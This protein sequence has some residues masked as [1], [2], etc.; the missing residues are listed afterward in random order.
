MKKTVLILVSFFFLVSCE[1]VI[2]VDLPAHKPGIVVNCVMKEGKPVSASITRSVG[3]LDTLEIEIING[4][5]VKLYENGVFVGTL[6][7][8]S[9]EGV[10]SVPGEYRINHNAVAGAEYRLEVSAPA[11][12]PV[13][14]GA[15]IPQAVPIASHVFTENASVNQFGE[16]MS[17]LSVTIND[18]AGIDNYY[19]LTI[20]DTTETESGYYFSMESTDPSVVQT[21]TGSGILFSDELFDGKTYTLK[22]DIPG[23]S[24]GTPFSQ[25][26]KVVLQTIDRNDFL[27]Q[28]TFYLHIE[29]EENPFAEPVQVY[30]N[31]NGGLGIFGGYSVN[32]VPL[33]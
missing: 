3:I 5:D 31:I 14:A 18:P 2:D 21:Y 13:Q 19:F 15:T 30:T 8:N 20:I 33:Y 32:S 26:M 23:F 10:D 6:L 12:D 24:G 22:A 27:Y 25:S 17:Q 16:Q 7:F 28:K 4:A 11:Y 9:Q 29:N 1:T